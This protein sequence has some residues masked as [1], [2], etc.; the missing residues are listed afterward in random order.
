MKIA[1]CC[2]DLE[3]RRDALPVL[4]LPS[5]N[6]RE[7]ERWVVLGPNGCGKSSLALALLGRLHPWE[8]SVEVLGL[9]SGRDDILPL[10]KGVAFSGDVLDPLVDSSVTC[11]DIVSTSF[12][13]TIGMKFDRPTPR[14]T[15]LARK[16][17]RAWGLSGL[18]TR[19]L[20]SLSLGQRRRAWLARAMAPKPRLLV[21]DEPCAGL[22][23]SAR[24]EFL[25]HLDLVSHEH[26]EL[27]IVLVTHHVEEIPPSFTHALILGGGSVLGQGPLFSTLNSR[28]LSRA[29][30]RSFKLSHRK[31]KFKL[32][33][34]K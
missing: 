1:V 12:V 28:A 29:F 32:D 2:R 17:L 18:E 34:L 30:G 16:E 4:K 3:L 14:Q 19:P 11:L 5:W 31:G 24:E 27:P 15:D 23:P 7:G 33:P 22:D 21:L 20:C 25:E 26:P 13:G 10:R 9:A 6:V 8:G